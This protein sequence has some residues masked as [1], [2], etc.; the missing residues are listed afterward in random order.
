M[1]ISIVSLYENPNLK[2]SVIDYCIDNWP[3]V[4]NTFTKNLEESLNKEDKLPLTYLL[5][6]DLKI[7]E[8]YQIVKEERIKNMNYLSPWLDCLFIDKNERG[9]AL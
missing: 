4:Q 6:K 3:K 1:N 7:I 5:M 8:F 9:K 2:E